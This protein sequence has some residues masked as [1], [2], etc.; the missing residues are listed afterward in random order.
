MS[1]LTIENS[2]VSFANI[3]HIDSLLSGKS[4]LNGSKD[5]RMD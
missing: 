4:L 3:L 1:S 2:E 5:S